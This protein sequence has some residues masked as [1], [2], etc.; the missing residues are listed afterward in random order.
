MGGGGSKNQTSYTY[1]DNTEKVRQEE[2][3]RER[4]RLENERRQ[5]ELQ[6]QERIEREK[7]EAAALE[8]QRFQQQLAEAERQEQERRREEEERILREKEQ[9]RKLEEEAVTKRLA[10]FDYKFGD[11]I[12]LASFRNLDISDVTKLRIGVFGPT[13][14]GKS[15]FVNTCERTVR[16]S[17]KGS[18]PINSTGRE[19]TIILEDFLQEMFFRLVDTRG[20]FNYNANESCEF[21]D[22]LSGRVRPG[23]TIKREQDEGF[24]GNN[25]G[26]TLEEV[27]HFSDRM[28][29]IILVVKANDIRLKKGQLKEYLLPVRQTLRPIGIS[30][31]TVVTHRDKLKTEAE[32]EQ[33]LNDAS[34]ATGSSRSHTFFVANYCPD[35]PGPNVNTELQ[36]FNILHFA[37]S[38]AERHVKIV[39]QQNKNKMEEDLM[40]AMQNAAI[41]APAKAVLQAP[42]SLFLEILQQK[43]KW[44]ENSVTTVTGKLHQEDISRLKT[45]AECWSDVTHFFPHG[46][47]ATIEKELVR[48]QLI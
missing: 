21:V 13:G 3:A 22:I 30:P 15:C 18:A 1:V 47:R 25:L 33:A 41:G 37:L 10:L 16:R 42:I 35:N 46:M 39:K 5:R 29:G 17:D 9:L 12:N 43:Y 44:S 2:E 11:K 8:R 6:E 20:F 27:D 40:S 7:R 24:E 31:I 48:L 14:S 19:G 32:C 45:L 26:S 38:M 36:I 34:A 4:R 28:H 23:S